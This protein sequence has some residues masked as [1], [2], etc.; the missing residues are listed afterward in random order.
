VFLSANLIYVVNFK[1]LIEGE[2]LF[3][4]MFVSSR[5]Y[6]YYKLSGNYVGILFSVSLFKKENHHSEI[7]NKKN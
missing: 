7:S 4:N 1:N 3:D 5:S 6:G 2:Y